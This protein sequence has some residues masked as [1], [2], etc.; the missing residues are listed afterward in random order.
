MRIILSRKGFDSENGG[1]PSP[2]F[3]DGTIVSLPIPRKSQLTYGQIASPAKNFRHL[4]EIV[5]H[6]TKYR[7]SDSCCVHLDPDLDSCSIKRETGWRGVFGQS[8]R[9]QREL[10]NAGVDVG[11]L[12]LFFGQF[13]KVKPSPTGQLS[14][15]RGA[16]RQQVIFGWLRIGRKLRLPDQAQSVPDWLR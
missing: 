1:V 10:E 3:P 13:C 16:K 15:V 2:I 11:D 4:G 7:L 12:L 5:E 6:L 9:A 8:E 14:Y